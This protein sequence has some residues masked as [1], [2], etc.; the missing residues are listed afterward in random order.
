MGIPRTYR[1]PVQQAVLVGVGIMFV[2]FGLG[3]I[4]RGS[5]SVAVG[6]PTTMFGGWIAVRAACM[7]VRVD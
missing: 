3:L 6:V 1:T 4:A 5:L 2:V 7:G